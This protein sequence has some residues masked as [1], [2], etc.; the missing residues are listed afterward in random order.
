MGLLLVVGA[1]AA[2]DDPAERRAL[3]RDFRRIDRIVRRTV[4]TGHTEPTAATAEIPWDADM[5]GYAGLHTLRRVAAWVDAGRGL[6]APCPGLA[7]AVAAANDPVGDAWY[8]DVE[9][10]LLDATRPRRRFE[11][12]M[13]HS[14]AAG[15]HVPVASPTV[16]VGTDAEQMKVGG[17]IGSS[18]TLRAELDE[19]AALMQ[20]DPALT[21]DDFGE[22]EDAAE[23]GRSP[24]LVEGFTCRLLQEACRVS[25]ASGA[26][27]VFC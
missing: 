17:V 9:S 13:A 27:I 18:V 5:I 24:W 8:D 1:L 20:L 26:A 23:T 3:Q 2:E 14:D 22:W 25:I 6:P 11:H 19:L 15:Y 7:A 12:L 10:W 21:W 4:P 16:F